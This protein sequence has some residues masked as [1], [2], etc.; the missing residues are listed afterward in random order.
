MA[1]N[2]VKV[3]DRPDAYCAD[4][5]E[6]ISREITEHDLYY[7]HLQGMIFRTAAEQKISMGW[8]SRKYMY[9][10]VT[11]R[12]E[13]ECAQAGTRKG[14]EL[15]FSSPLSMNSPETIVEMVL[16]LDRLPERKAG[17]KKLSELMASGELDLTETDVERSE[18]ENPDYAYWLGYVYRYEAFLH[19]ESSRNIF[20]RLKESFMREFYDRISKTGNIQLPE[21][22]AQICQRIDAM[23]E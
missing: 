9:S 21:H 5:I 22:A 17:E 1:Y 19:D 14:L 8:F 20:E 18:M 16:R 6:T 12:M 4:E 11:M 3:A 2:Y 13:S 23:N 10:R 15:T 7:C